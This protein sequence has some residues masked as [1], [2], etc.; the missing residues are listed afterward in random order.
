MSCP[1]AGLRAWTRRVATVVAVTGAAVWLVVP[2]SSAAPSST[3]G[4]SGAGDPYFPLLG[5][6]GHAVGHYAPA[7]TATPSTGSI[8][9]VARIT[10]TA[11][12]ALTR[13]D[14][15]LR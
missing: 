15:D 4:A 13:F 14:L 8:S 11:T 6:G 1:P 5:N 9:G 12:Q 7:L 10:A 2:P 3:V